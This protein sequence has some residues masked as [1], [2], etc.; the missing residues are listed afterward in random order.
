M[1]QRIRPIWQIMT[2]A[3]DPTITLTCD[4]CFAILDH[5]ATLAIA[6]A[7]DKDLKITVHTYLAHCPDCEEYYEQRIEELQAWFE[8]QRMMRE[9]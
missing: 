1:A 7:D 6:G 9:A 5:L 2:T 8:R 4:E 3:V